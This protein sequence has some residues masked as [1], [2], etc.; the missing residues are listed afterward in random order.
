MDQ[1]GNILDILVISKRDEQA[2]KR[3]FRKLLKGCQYVPRVF[4]T[5]L[6][7]IRGHF[8]LS[9]HKWSGGEYRAQRGQRFQ[10]WTEVTGTRMAAYAVGSS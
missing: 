3:F 4:I 5:E 9:R 7:P 8:R 10:N 6:E 2:A 1:H